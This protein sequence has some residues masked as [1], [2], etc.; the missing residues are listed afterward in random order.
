MSK[1]SLTRILSRLD[2]AASATQ[3]DSVA[4]DA[5]ALLPRLRS[6]GRVADY[7]RVVNAIG[8]AARRLASS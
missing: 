4:P 1:S 6:A 8:A 7:A 2:S 3:F 5:A